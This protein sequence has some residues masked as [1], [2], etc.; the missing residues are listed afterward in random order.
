MIAGDWSKAVV[1]LRQ[2]LTYQVFDTGVISDDSGVVVLNLMQQDAVA[3][4]CVMRCAWAVA[5]P[6]TPTSGQ[7]DA[8]TFAFGALVS[9]P[10]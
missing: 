4:R 5:D 2:D 6:V 10:T 7:S 9:Q 8:N 3:L 1:G